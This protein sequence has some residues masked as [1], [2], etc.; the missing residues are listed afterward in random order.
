MSDFPNTDG[1]SASEFWIQAWEEA[2]ASD[3]RVGNDTEEERFWQGYAPAYDDRNPLAP[4]TQE[5]MKQVYAY[6]K[7]DDRL[8]E[9]GPGTGGFTQLLAPH[10][11]ELALV[12]P[13]TS[14]FE[15]LCHNWAKLVAPLPQLLA[16]KW[17]EAPEV[18][19]DVVFS[20]NA[21]YRIRDMKDSLLKM[22]Q[23]ARRHVF[24]VQSIGQPFAGPLRVTENGEPQER[25]RAEVISSILDELN[26]EHHYATFPVQ[27]KSGEIHDVALIHWSV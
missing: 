17:E 1:L 16:V 3:L 25:V 5:L 26:I 6:L 21:F 15:V 24:L 12:E 8:L 9:I 19:A 10:V 18:E 4:Y 22:H 7:A 20:A 14:M 11:G 23:T 2:A 27:R 13:S